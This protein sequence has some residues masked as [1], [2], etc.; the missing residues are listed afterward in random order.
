MNLLLNSI[1]FPLL[2]ESNQPQDTFTF[3]IKRSIYVS[4]FNRGVLLTDYSAMHKVSSSYTIYGPSQSW[5]V[6]YYDTIFRGILKT[7]YPLF[8]AFLNRAPRAPEGVAIR[9]QL[10]CFAST[11]LWFRCKSF[12]S[13]QEYYRLISSAGNPQGFTSPW[14]VSLRWRRMSGRRTEL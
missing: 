3:C 4:G 7:L 13:S 11:L 2:S 14:T 9:S 6:I 1:Y 5:L 10:T 8:T 12:R